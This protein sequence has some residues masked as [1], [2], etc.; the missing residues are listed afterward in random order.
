MT[1][2]LKLPKAQHGFL[3][4]FHVRHNRYGVKAWENLNWRV[5]WSAGRACRTRVQKRRLAK[6]FRRTLRAKAPCFPSLENRNAL[7]FC[8]GGV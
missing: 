4:H 6:S 8:D 3:F 5:T 2:I 7:T 1:F